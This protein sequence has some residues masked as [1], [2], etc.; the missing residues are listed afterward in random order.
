MAA[1]ILCYYSG[2]CYS[3]SVLLAAKWRHLL[4]FKKKS[5]FTNNCL[6]LRFGRIH[7]N[8]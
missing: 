1:G 3:V 7:I 6:K 5:S 8:N 4:I 2:E